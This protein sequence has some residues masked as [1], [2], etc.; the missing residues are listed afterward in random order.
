MRCPWQACIHF[1]KEKIAR[2]S[3]QVTKNILLYKN[4]LSQ[5]RIQLRGC[6][7]SDFF[8]NFIYLVVSKCSFWRTIYDSEC[9]TDLICPKLCSILK[10]IHVFYFFNDI[11]SIFT[12]NLVIVIECH[13]LGYNKRNITNSGWI[14]TDFLEFP[15]KL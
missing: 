8:L 4:Y 7:F 13:I 14:F 6:L 9:M 2:T 3:S 1:S 12:N 11:S 15:A 5:H 10:R